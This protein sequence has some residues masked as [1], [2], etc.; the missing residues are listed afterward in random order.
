MSGI[1]APVKNLNRNPRQANKRLLQQNLP[2]ADACTAANCIS[3]RSPCRVV[4]RAPLAPRAKA[5]TESHDQ[6]MP[7][8]TVSHYRRAAMAR[9]LPLDS[10]RIV[11]WNIAAKINMA[12]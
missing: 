12:G 1:N 6:A 10:A 3:I 11:M 8:G 7:R 4:E 2:K 5:I 9:A